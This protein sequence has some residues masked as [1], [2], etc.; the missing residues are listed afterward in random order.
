MAAVAAGGAAL[1]SSVSSASTESEKIKVGILGGT[2]AVG[3]RFIQYLEGHPQ[4]E[5][6]GIG[7]SE[8][9]AGKPYK[10]AAKWMLSADVPAF[11]KDKTVVNCTPE[12]MKSVDLVF[13]ALDT[14]Q[15]RAAEPLFAAAGVPVFSNAS[16][17][18]MD[19]KTPLVVPPVNGDHL[20]LAKSQ[21][22]YAKN[23]G[24][25]VTNANCST[26][27]LVI[28]L[29][30]IHEAFGIETATI[31]TLQ[32]ISG[33]GYPGLSGLDVLDN[34]IPNINGE[35]EK[36]EIEY[37]K[38]L[39]AF[40]PS[41]STSTSTA[42][43]AAAIRF[44]DF[45]LSAMV[46]RVHVRDGHTISVSLKLKQHATPEQIAAVLRGY[47]PSDP[48]VSSLPSSPRDWIVVREEPDR[49]QPR[50]DRDTGRGFTT[51]V[52]KIRPDPVATVKFV[53]LSHNTVMG[54]AGSS[55][56]NAE[57]AVEKGLVKKKQH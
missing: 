33:A 55:I 10:T 5:V 51:V 8:R 38:I 39:G 40:K 6:A 25:I 3:Q 22:T 45:P 52:G 1:L 50:L 42:A 12:D 47:K 46:H 7:A 48:A 43:A 23:G 29:K 53:V 27:G 17:F 26:T 35:E 41:S 13:S 11:V 36:L 28:A 54:A 34:M 2:G 4:F 44:A 56:L 32:A 37:K 19:A 16:A 49:P 21:P 31:A 15:A 30:P 14:E 57:L 9:S 18:R 24:F 20:E